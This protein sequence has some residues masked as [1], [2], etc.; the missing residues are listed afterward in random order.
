MALLFQPILKIALG[1]EL[2]NIVAVIVAVG[3][4]LSLK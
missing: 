3:L 4:M 1:R 2:W